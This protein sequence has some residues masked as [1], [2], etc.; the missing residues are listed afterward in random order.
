MTVRRDDTA[1]GRWIDR[2]AAAAL[3]TAS[4]FPTTKRAIE[5]WPIRRQDAQRQGSCC[6]KRM[7]SPTPISS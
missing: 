4:Y 6:A 5:R 3:V 2:R 1:G 7:C